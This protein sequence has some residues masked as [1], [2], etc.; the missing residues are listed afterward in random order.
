MVISNNR[1]QNLDL[2][3]FRT[4]EDACPYNVWRKSFEHL[5]PH[6]NVN[7]IRFNLTL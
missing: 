4:I 5:S 7:A 1:L 6:G 2:F 3:G